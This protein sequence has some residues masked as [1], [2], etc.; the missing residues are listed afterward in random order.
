MLLYSY[1][2]GDAQRE[3]RKNKWL[4]M[5]TYNNATL[6]A[7][8]EMAEGRPE[9]NNGVLACLGKTALWIEWDFANSQ[10]ADAVNAINRLLEEK[11]GDDEV[12]KIFDISC[13]TAALDIAIAR[14]W[15]AW[16]AIKSIID[17]AKNA[18]YGVA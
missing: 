15:A 14:K 6:E 10:T 5:N 17:A 16:A 4:E 2:I 3:A 11:Y 1:Y 13:D 8:I 12:A 7:I 9:Y 18:I